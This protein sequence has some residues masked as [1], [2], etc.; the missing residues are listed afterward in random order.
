MKLKK[1]RISVTV[2]R[3]NPNLPGKFSL[4]IAAD[5]DSTDRLD[6]L[7]QSRDLHIALEAEADRRIPILEGSKV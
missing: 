6:A 2:E 4:S 5:I 1:V 3:D 7:M